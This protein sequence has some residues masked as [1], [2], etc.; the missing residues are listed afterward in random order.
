MSNYEDALVKELRDCASE[1]TKIANSEV[2]LEKMAST[3]GTPASS[4]RH[5]YLTGVLEGLGIR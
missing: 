5:D 2:D 3:Q 1:L 4:N